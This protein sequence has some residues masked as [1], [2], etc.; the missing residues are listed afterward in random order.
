MSA[1]NEFERPGIE[2]L[3]SDFFELAVS[4]VDRRDVGLDNASLNRLSVTF[5]V[6]HEAIEREKEIRATRERTAYIFTEGVFEME[7]ENTVIDQV[8]NDD[9]SEQSGSD[10]EPVTS[11]M[12]DRAAAET[13]SS[14][15]LGKTVDVEEQTDVSSDDTPLK[16]TESA[17]QATTL[18]QS[19]IEKSEE[20]TAEEKFILNQFDELQPGQVVGKSFFF[21]K[22]FDSVNDRA[23]KIAYNQAFVNAMKFLIEKGAVVKPTRTSYLLAEGYEAFLAQ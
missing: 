8:A 1:V 9:L 7:S 21:E 12:K 19:T 17:P 10:S 5:T 15:V 11:E 4:L 23:S 22:G 18:D 16:V 2:R 3:A 13:V 14:L 6:M 20:L